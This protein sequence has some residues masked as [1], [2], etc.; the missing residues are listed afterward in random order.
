MVSGISLKTMGGGWRECWG[1]G[2]SLCAPLSRSVCL[3]LSLLHGCGVQACALG[4]AWR[5][6]AHWILTLLWLSQGWPTVRQSLR[7][8]S[9]HPP[10]GRLMPCRPG[11]SSELTIV[12]VYTGLVLAPT[13][14]R[15][16]GTGRG[17]GL[18]RTLQPDSVSRAS[19]WP[20][21][22][23]D[24]RLCMSTWWGVWELWGVPDPQGS[25]S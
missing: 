19:P 14:G 20:R 22:M 21:A 16:E 12:I 17:L 6:P 23:S 4:L 3:T 13:A 18:A 7:L 1:C 2:H 25:V 15:A 11:Q 9:A 24:C 5:P 10:M 8:L